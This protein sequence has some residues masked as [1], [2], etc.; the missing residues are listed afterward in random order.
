METEVETQVAEMLVVE[1]PV[2]VLVEAVPEEVPVEA[3]EVEISEE[4]PVKEILVA[5]AALVL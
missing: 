1:G 5:K 3:L 4:V 2:V